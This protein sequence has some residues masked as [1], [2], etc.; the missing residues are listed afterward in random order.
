METPNH[1]PL[2]DLVRGLASSVEDMRARMQPL[3]EINLNVLSL[4]ERECD[5]GSE[6]ERDE[7]SIELNESYEPSC[8]FEVPIEHERPPTPKL[9]MQRLLEMFADDEGVT[10]RAKGDSYEIDF[11]PPTPREPIVSTTIDGEGE[12]LEY[13]PPLEYDYV[14]E[15]DF[16][17]WDDSDEEVEEVEVR[18]E[19]I[20]V[21]GDVPYD[22]FVE[23]TPSPPHDFEETSS[24]VVSNASHTPL[25]SHE[26]EYFDMTNLFEF[27]LPFPHVL[28]T[29]SLTLLLW[30]IFSI[31][32]TLF[33]HRAISST[34]DLLLRALNRIY[35]AIGQA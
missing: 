24:F 23:N 28:P 7:A 16:E 25:G 14:D 10:I 5:L 15:C 30:F 18:D 32:A 27:K 9:D 2:E 12:Q 20:E 13:T 21:E 34:H 4:N 11:S 8:G 31:V 3:P 26:D 35:K 22:T 1:S 17:E 29:H 6:V 19:E 33:H